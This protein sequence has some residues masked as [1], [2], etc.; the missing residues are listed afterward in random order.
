MEN[1]DK[2]TNGAVGAIGFLLYVDYYHPKQK[3]LN[4][5]ETRGVGHILRRAVVFLQ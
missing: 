4:L 3:P 5:D 2:K 1:A